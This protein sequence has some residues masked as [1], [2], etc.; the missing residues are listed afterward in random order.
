MYNLIAI[1]DDPPVPGQRLENAKK[2]AQELGMAIEC[3]QPNS[4]DAFDHCKGVLAKLDSNTCVILDLAFRPGGSPI[5]ESVKA[6]LG[7]LK[8]I[9]N[10]I[11][12]RETKDGKYCLAI[13]AGNEC[14]TIGD[15]LL[16]GIA[17]LPSILQSITEHKHHKVLVISATSRGQLSG[18]RKLF[19]SLNSYAKQQRLNVIFATDEDGRDLTELNR[20]KAIF[21]DTTAA[22]Q[23]AFPDFHEDVWVDGLVSHW[24]TG[25]RTYV[26]GGNGTRFCEH[27]DIDKQ[28]DNYSGLLKVMLQHEFSALDSK[29]L[30]ALMQLGVAPKEGAVPASF[31]QT[32]NVSLPIPGWHDLPSRFLLEILPHL[33][34]GNGKSTTQPIKLKVALERIRLPVCPGLNVL[35]ALR[36]LSRK[37]R[38][39]EYEDSTGQRRKCILDFDKC[40]EVQGRDG[41]PY[42]FQIPLKEAGVELRYGLARRWVEKCSNGKAFSQGN[43]VCSA[44]WD[45][46]VGRVRVSRSSLTD[47]SEL[48]L[49]GALDGPGYPV[50]GVSFAAHYI[51]LYWH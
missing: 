47:P 41:G 31:F 22:W 9:I 4:E 48:A 35:V 28:P 29:S 6:A 21:K 16:D 17:L 11:D 26:K 20:A 25:Y 8:S 42:R 24:L 51:N 7:G 30:K 32:S 2:A 23:K 14:D 44:L 46:L 43:G 50:L 38:E 12:F 19:A 15:E 34:C 36:L 13:T 45:L 33:L 40:F 37:L 18:V 5:W 3:H 39:Q 1:D 49:L 27:D 10:G